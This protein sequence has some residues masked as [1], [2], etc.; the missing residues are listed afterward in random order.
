MKKSSVVESQSAKG[1][2]TD[3]TIHRNAVE[4]CLV[5]DHKVINMAELVRFQP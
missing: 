3:I 1:T 2:V 5:S 4:N